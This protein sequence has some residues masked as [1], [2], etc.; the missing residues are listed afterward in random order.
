MK[1]K[2]LNG[3]TMAAAVSLLSYAIKYTVLGL[4]TY[5]L[6]PKILIS[7]YNEG[8]FFGAAAVFVIIYVHHWLTLKR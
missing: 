6:N 8:M 2:I 4:N 5:V 7:Q 1:R 3:F